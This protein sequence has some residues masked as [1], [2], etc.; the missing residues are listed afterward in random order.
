MAARLVQQRNF[1]VLAA[2]IA[3]D[4]ITVSANKTNTTAVS[5]MSNS[6][7]VPDEQVTYTTVMTDDATDCDDDARAAT[8]LTEL[9]ESVDENAEQPA[10]EDLVVQHNGDNDDDIEGGCAEEMF[11][12]SL[13]T[14]VEDEITATDVDMDLVPMAEV[15][16]AGDEQAMHDENE[17]DETVSTMHD[18]DAEQ[19]HH[20]Q[21]PIEH[22]MLSVSKVQTF[23]T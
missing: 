10:T 12:H 18:A 21:H 23:A 5:T 8:G 9:H 22:V 20:Q 3:G 6:N 1:I 11:E 17:D 2:N 19:L 13:A 15:D 16:V 7:S 4:E 14:N